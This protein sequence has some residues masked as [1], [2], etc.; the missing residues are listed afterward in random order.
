MRSFFL[1]VLCVFLAKSI[2][3]QVDIVTEEQPRSQIEVYED[4]LGL[5]SFLIVNDSLE[6][7]R[8]LAVKKFIPTLVN[9][10]KE[11]NSFN[12][13]FERLQS[14]SIQYPADSTFR[15]FTWQLYVD[16]DDYRYYGAIQ[17][18]SDSLKLFPLLDRSFQIQEEL[19]YKSLPPEQ[20][21]GSLY[22][23]IRDFDTPKGRKY[24]LFGFDGYSFFNK[25][26]VVDVLSFNQDK[27]V[28]GA[29]VF[30]NASPSAPRPKSRVVLTYSAETAVKLN[31]DEHLDLVIFD[32]LIQE[33]GLAGQG[34]TQLPDGS[35]EGYKLENGQWMYVEKVFHQVSE[36][37]PREEPV[38]ND[39]KKRKNR[40]NLFGQR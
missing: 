25:R 2:D 23:N 13:P 31:Y 26:K 12:Y 14:V 16:K 40:K 3:A 19:D 27:P 10:L 6:E 22:Y 38:F 21:Y 1:L 33:M 28:F 7:N 39:K 18:N 30:V 34:P 37:A 11:P 5:L 32:H 15:I 29:P 4:T 35:Y 20:W 24:L 17:M 9:A 8:F 36:E